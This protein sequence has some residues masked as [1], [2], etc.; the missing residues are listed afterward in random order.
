MDTST[1]STYLSLLLNTAAVAAI[2]SGIFGYPGSW[3]VLSRF[4][5]SS[6]QAVFG[7]LVL[8]DTAPA[9]VQDA[10][11]PQSP[12]PSSP[13]PYSHESSDFPPTESILFMEPESP[14]GT[15]PNRAPDSLASSS[16]HM[17]LVSERGRQ[18][19]EPPSTLS[20]EIDDSVVSLDRK[21]E[22]FI[23]LNSHRNDHSLSFSWGSDQHGLL[24]R[25]TL[26]ALFERLQGTEDDL[27]CPI[28]C[29][30]RMA[31]KAPVEAYKGP[32]YLLGR[33][34]PT[35]DCVDFSRATNL[36]ELFW[37]GDISLLGQKC[38]NVPFH[39]LRSLSMSGTTICV[40]DAISL[41]HSC[42]LLV[43]AELETVRNE[44]IPEMYD[45]S[46]PKPNTRLDVSL[47]QLLELKVTAVE[48]L[49][50]LFDAI[51]WHKLDRLVL[52]VGNRA[53]RKLGNTLRRHVECGRGHVK[54][55]DV[56]VVSSHLQPQELR[57]LAEDFPGFNYNGL[58]LRL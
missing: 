45:D 4:I 12:P 57:A 13:S 30:K 31:F 54:K 47:G 7:D 17:P 20:I 50:P 55:L 23:R 49:K 37:Q 56:A 10:R 32:F 26:Q 6:A 46:A 28:E 25:L 58:P 51:S 35:H 27:D 16:N 21:V 33:R 43:S 36:E 39:Q 18:L 5:T 3:D 52:V 53:L 42:P 38:I 14:I 24:G 19:P 11:I 15:F 34:L 2:S 48:D 41:L 44:D 29:F 40:A 8:Q 22:R 9:Q 1:S